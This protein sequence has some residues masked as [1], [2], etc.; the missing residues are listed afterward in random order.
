MTSGPTLTDD[1][2]QQL[3]EI[4]P[5]LEG[6]LS[7]LTSDA[8]PIRALF[9]SVKRGV[10]PGLLDAL[11]RLANIDDYHGKMKKAK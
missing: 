3:I 7:T 9:M 6:D 8:D 1:A 4:M 11:S 2:K 10:P 5:L